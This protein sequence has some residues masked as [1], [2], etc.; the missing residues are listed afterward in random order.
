MKLWGFTLN[1]WQVGLCLVGL[2]LVLD[3]LA[4]FIIGKINVGTVIPLLVGSWLL[5]H[6]LYGQEIGQYLQDH[7][8][9]KTV[10]QLAWVGFWLWL[11]SFMVFVIVLNQAIAIGN[12][13]IIQNTFSP[14][15]IITLGSGF[16][17]GQPTP[18]LAS[19]LDKTA[20]LEKVY[21]NAVLVLTGGVDLN[22][23][24]SEAEV[25]AKYLQQHY[26][27]SF[28]KMR[29]EDKSTST[30]LN[31]QNSQPILAE[32]GISLGEPIAIVTSD[33]H[34]LRAKAIAKKQGYSNVQT[35]GSITPLSIRYNAWLR[36]YFAFVSG[37][38]LSEY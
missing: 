29:L 32:S 24:Q 1:Y 35:F 37:W 38:V 5:I 18:T 31:L 7:S 14:K 28:A 15:A 34:T 10:W 25:M 36:E 17:N 27:I 16:K 33:F 26:A 23:T 19:R 12:H 13:S 2:L 9:I 20:E 22:E 30:E 8:E 6:G 21:P 11:V 3:A 4:L